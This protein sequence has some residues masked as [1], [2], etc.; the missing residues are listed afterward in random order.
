MSY[1]ST[2]DAYIAQVKKKAEVLAR[3]P[4]AP[5]T[6]A[7]RRSIEPPVYRNYAHQPPEYW[8]DQ[9]S[10]NAN[11]IPA[12][13]QKD[14]MNSGFGDPMDDKE[15][16]TYENLSYAKA[17]R[18]F[19][20]QR[21]KHFEKFKRKF[22][23]G[24]PGHDF[25][26]K[27]QLKDIN[28]NRKGFKKSYSKMPRYT[29]R[30]R[31]G[32]LANTEYA[33]AKFSTQR[34]NWGKNNDKYG[35]GFGVRGS[36]DNVRAFGPN[37]AMASDGQRDLRAQYGWKG[38][39][40]Y[41]NWAR[42]IPR[43]IGAIGGAVR[44]FGTGGFAGALM[45]GAKGYNQGAGFSKAL[46]WGDYQVKNQIMGGGAT[47]G[48]DQQ[49]IQV[50]Q[51]SDNGDIYIAH[52]EFVKNITVTMAAA[53]NSPF[54][55]EVLELNA[56]LNETFPFLSQLA[57]NYV[58]YDFEGLVF[59]YKPSSGESAGNSNAL[60]K[61]IMA[62]NYD[63]DAS[64]FIN[65]IQM[66]NYDYA[67]SCKPSVGMLHGV[68]TD[69]TQQVVNM[70]YIRTGPISKA[71]VFT[72]I[73]TFQIAT[74]GVPLAAAGT[75][76]LGELWVSY[77]VKL[78]RANLYG[79][80][81]GS[82]AGYDRFFLTTSAVANLNTLVFTVG[83]ANT[84]GATCAFTSNTKLLVTFPTTIVAGAYYVV[85]RSST[86]AGGLMIWNAPTNNLNCTMFTPGNVPIAGPA[87]FPAP[88]VGG[89][90]NLL[91]S[92]L[93]GVFINAPGN[94]QASVEF[95]TS[96]AFNVAGDIHILILQVPTNAALLGR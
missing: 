91:H 56:G 67:A 94:A 49:V 54:N 66:E 71:K 35:A 13:E 11:I 29:K 86:V 23:L 59:Q 73:G 47:A 1:Q 60:G 79:S 53:G 34:A 38:K 30:R 70:T 80:V 50:N 78:S 41:R 5:G 75:Q 32:G 21:M 89:A 17:N 28:L 26:R 33:L 27:E 82:N 43:G 37:W 61:I 10:G 9:G 81:M 63:P 65:A 12:I 42:W 22:K 62:T 57:Q 83:A 92:F 6:P 45:G 96:I 87:H 16:N 90:A 68:E 72:D 64:P 84:I 93:A 55:I 24:T 48:S 15:Q 2:L 18:K 8:P 44:G 40:D 88:S 52:S 39:G 51:E 3:R 77:R 4:R 36:G 85:C 14:N 74:E 95:N 46:G 7:K 76:I 58:L 20:Y 69:N 31:R 19:K 25:W